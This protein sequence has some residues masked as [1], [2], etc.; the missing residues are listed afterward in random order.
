M[1]RVAV[2]ST[3]I[4]VNDWRQAS[5]DRVSYLFWISVVF[6]KYWLETA[7]LGFVEFLFGLGKLLLKGPLA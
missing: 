4:A 7:G 5:D 2:T 3:A 1:G 6:G